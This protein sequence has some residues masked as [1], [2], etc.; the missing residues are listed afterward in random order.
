MSA[1][2]RIWVAI[3]ERGD[4][5]MNSQGEKLNGYSTHAE[6]TRADLAPAAPKV[7]AL[8]EAWLGVKN[9]PRISINLQGS[10][11]QHSWDVFLAALAALEGGDG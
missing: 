11:A 9:H 4:M 10:D 5:A 6:Y 8:V 1:P 2:E 7:K 3:S